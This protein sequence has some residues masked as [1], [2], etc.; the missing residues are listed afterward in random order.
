MIDLA[1]DLLEAPAGL[2]GDR[3]GI[4]SQEERDGSVWKGIPRFA[5]I[6]MLLQTLV[7]LFLSFWLYEEYLNNSYFQAYVNGIL[8]GSV[9]TA[10]VLI[11]IVAFTVVAIVLFLKLRSTRKEL[12]GILSKEKAGSEGGGHG[13]PLDTRTEQHLIEM[14]RKTTPIMNSGPGTGGEMPTLRRTDSQSSPEEQ[15]SSQ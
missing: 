12:E 11:S 14:I 2:F 7:V 3:G 5:K 15:G 4:T 13:Q 6:I 8:Q 10:V 9:F 1:L